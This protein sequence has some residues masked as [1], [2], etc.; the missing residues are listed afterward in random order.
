MTNKRLHFGKVGQIDRQMD[1]QKQMGWQTY[2]KA[3]M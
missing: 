2:E 1:R 3:A